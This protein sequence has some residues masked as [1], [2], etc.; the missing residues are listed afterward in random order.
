M[1]S[2]DLIAIYIISLIKAQKQ[3]RRF[4]EKLLNLQLCFLPQS[5]L[6]LK[7]RVK[8]LP[9]FVSV[10]NRCYITHLVYIGLVV[11]ETS[12]RWQMK[13]GLCLFHYFLHTLKKHN[14]IV[15]GRQV[16]FNSSNNRPWWFN[17]LQNF[18]TIS[19][20]SC[21]LQFGWWKHE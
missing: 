5:Y 7:L 16:L 19:Q 4:L 13:C 6:P 9:F 3:K 20:S 8:K 2:S 1:I 18:K 10:R 17:Y 21:S 15:H 14:C 12:L 11:L